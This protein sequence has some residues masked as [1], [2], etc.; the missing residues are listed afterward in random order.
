MSLLFGQVVR[1]MSAGARVF[2]YLVIKP[3]IPVTGGTQMPLENIHGQVDFKNV[4]FS[5]P[6]RPTQAVLKDFTLSMPA[7]KMVALC[8]SSGAGKSTVAALLE[9]FYD[10]DS[11]CISV[12]GHDIA[13]LDPTWLR[14]TVIGFIHQVFGIFY[15]I[16][17]FLMPSKLLKVHGELKSYCI[18]VSC[19][20]M[21]D[22]R[23]YTHN[24]SSSEIKA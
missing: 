3:S 18:T 23:S 20:F 1:G 11:G 24:L 14:G 12:D 19:D 15:V 6:T 16:M 8:G 22:H 5:Y 10:V 13:G 17:P 9:R 21:I 4:T 7:G 2:E